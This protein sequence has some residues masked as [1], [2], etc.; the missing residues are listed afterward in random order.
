MSNGIR[1]SDF[2]ILSA[3]G[4]SSFGIDPPLPVDTRRSGKQDRRFPTLSTPRF[5]LK[6]PAVTA[7]WITYRPE[8][9]VLDCTIRDGGL[10]NDH[11]F[12]TTGS[13]RPSTRPA[14]QPASTTWRSA[15]RTRRS[16][17]PRTSSAPGSICDEDD[18]RRIVGENDT[19]LKLTA[20]A[21]AGKS[22][23]QD[24]HPAQAARAC[25]T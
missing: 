7:P 16:C 10:I 4:I 6:E 8:L 5:P 15:T 21:D 9:K 12:S 1:G 14:W 23:W 18:I 3:L 20:M 17:S 25:W 24:R 19:P 11:Q 13:S 22:D 2:G